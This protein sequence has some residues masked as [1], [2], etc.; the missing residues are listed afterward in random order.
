VTELFT[1]RLH[2][3]PFNAADFE[4]HAEICADAEVMR[5]IRAGALS[6]VEAWW[7]L[8]RYIGHWQ[9]RGYGLWAVVERSSDRL[10][11]HLGF[12]NPEGG[13]GFELGWAFARQA[14]GKGYALE[15]VRAAVQYAFAELDRDH[16]LCLIHPENR[17]SIR[18]AERL[19]AVP[20]PDIT[21]SGTRLLAYGISRSKGHSHARAGL[22][23]AP[24]GS[25]PDA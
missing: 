5:Y 11:G 3:R 22:T 1:D 18:L 17:R 23:P 14:W 6:R 21:Q 16:L 13:H 19:G 12:L 9:L 25:G 10:I 4:G 20:E 2:L 24:G 8:A 7:Q 15:G